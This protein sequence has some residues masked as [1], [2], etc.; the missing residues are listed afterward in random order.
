MKNAYIIIIGDEI[1]YGFTHDHNSHY[2]AFHLN[3]AGLQVQTVKV[4]NDDKETIKETFREALA[5]ADV[6]VATGGLGPTRDDITKSTLAEVFD[7][8]IVYSEKAREY[9]EAFVQQR[10]MNLDNRNIG[11]TYIPAKAKPLKN[12]HGMAPGLLF[13]E[14]GQITVALPGV[15]SEMQYLTDEEV[16]P[17]VN[18]HLNLPPTQH[19]QFL[20]AGIPEVILHEKIQDMETLL[21]QDISLAYLP[22]W[23][24]VKLRLTGRGYTHEAFREAIKP[25][26]DQLH[27]KVGKYIFGYDDQTLPEVVGN[28][29]QAQNAT[30]ATAESCTGGYL[31]HLITSVSGSSAYFR[32]SVISYT[33]QVKAQE[34]G[35]SD[36]TL[37]KHG[38][39][40]EPVVTQMVK[41]MNQKWGTD[42][43]IAT[44]G[45]AGPSGGTPDKPVG[46]V[47]I[48][49][50]T[51]DQVSTH[52]FHFFK[53]RFKNIHFSGIMGL[54]MLR[55]VLV[56]GEAN[57]KKS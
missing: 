42:Y 18:D 32:G 34:L 36:A 45:V 40:S 19:T 43:A 55:R 49:A 23:G 25:F 28:K 7:C 5:K 41:G 33:N 3:Q 21:P 15:P 48:A 16:I 52:C 13:D 44:S 47:W 20:T 35:V 9:V 53:D 12:E 24:M 46:M 1:L 37:E 14:N 17:Y 31:A 11:H 2:L 8:E 54:D 4:I 10:N 57:Y 27:Q 22:E 56:Y 29:L 26:S 39:V 30:L 38:A 51:T 50:G 6:I